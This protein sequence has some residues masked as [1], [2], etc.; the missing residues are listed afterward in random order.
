MYI[1]F[2]LSFYGAIGFVFY[3]L[4]KRK[5][6]ASLSVLGL[7][8][9]FHLFVFIIGVF[10]ENVFWGVFMTGMSLLYWSW[11][12][13]VFFVPSLFFD[14]WRIKRV[15]IQNNKNK[16]K[17]TAIA[18]IFIVFVSGFIFVKYP[19]LFKMENIEID[20]M[21]DFGD[22][23]IIVTLPQSGQI[24]YSPLK[25]NGHINDNFKGG[26]EGDFGSVELLDA[27]R[28]RIA[29]KQL[30]VDATD[31]QGEYKERPYFFEST[32][33]FDM[34]QTEFGTLIFYEHTARGDMTEKLKLPVKFG[35]NT[36]SIEELSKD[37][38]KTYKNNQ[39][40]FEITYP[41]KLNNV[42]EKAP[43]SV[44]G[45]ADNPVGGI[46]VGPLVF[47]VLDSNNLR[48]EARDYFDRYYNYNNLNNATKEE[49]SEEGGMTC[50]S[51]IIKNYLFTRYVK[52]HGGG[53]GGAYALIKGDEFDIFVDWY[54][55]GFKNGFGDIIGLS[56]EEAKE[57]ISTFKFVNEINSNEKSV[58]SSDKIIDPSGLYQFTKIDGWR[59][60]SSVFAPGQ[61]PLGRQVSQLIL[62]TDNF[63][64]HMVNNDGF[65]RK[66]YDSG[67]TLNITI[68]RGEFEIDHGNAQI[69]EN[70]KVNL[71]GGVD[72]EYHRFSESTFLG[73]LRDVHVNYQGNYYVIRFAYDIEN[74][75]KGE[76]VFKQILDSFEFI[77]G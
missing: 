25:I 30:V 55:G 41:N 66:K 19:E 17:I 21:E 28:K 12:F 57:I 68:T 39:Y 44:L 6:F 62:E 76:K 67:A 47:V 24:V 63:S 45:D 61:V 9:L 35:K 48:N 71:K 70:P 7:Y 69:F 33:L 4:L 73:Q 8:F 51:E 10:N 3:V 75:P 59:I 5:A 64:S 54:S 72:G 15:N 13:L 29:S 37:N 2:S 18:L 50:S 34:P 32:L 11:L 1:I 52:C 40:G 49:E 23:G 43:N 77:E 53:G 58:S 56:K 46:Y 20:S 60:R 65:S 14:F 27:N 22:V 16:I 74:Y 36:A 31:E 38:W 26:W 42:G